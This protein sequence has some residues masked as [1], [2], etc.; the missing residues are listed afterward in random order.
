MERKSI[1]AGFCFFLFDRVSVARPFREKNKFKMEIQTENN[2]QKQIH[3]IT[4]GNVIKLKHDFQVFSLVAARQLQVQVSVRQVFMSFKHSTFT[5]SAQ[6][7]LNLITF[8]KYFHSLIHKIG[9][10]NV[11]KLPWKFPFNLFI[12]FHFISFP[13]KSLTTFFH[14]LIEKC[15]KF[16]KSN[17][18]RIT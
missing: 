18:N 2:T 4:V 17:I 13:L 10:P 8:V 16:F 5:H 9:L 12:S 7:L 14:F 6:I 15:W 1:P 3:L 11:S